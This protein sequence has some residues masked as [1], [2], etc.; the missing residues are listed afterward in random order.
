MIK[1]PKEI[2]SYKN[3]HYVNDKLKESNKYAPEVN[4][5]NY[6][7]DIM[8]VK[9]TPKQQE[10][11]EP[12]R[13]LLSKGHGFVCSTGKK[14]QTTYE[15][16]YLSVD[17]QI[18]MQGNVC[19]ARDN[20]A[21]GSINYDAIALYTK[22]YQDPKTHKTKFVFE[23]YNWQTL[24]SFSIIFDVEKDTIESTFPDAVNPFKPTEE[25]CGMFLLQHGIELNLYNYQEVKITELQKSYEEQFASV[26][27]LGSSVGNSFKSL[28][29]LGLMLPRLHSYKEF[30]Q[31]E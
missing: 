4:N 22:I 18:D 21:T 25:E 31:N 27:N 26:F 9:L 2:R 17:I 29:S 11:I 16:G 28:A 10:F 7:L 6:L 24:I 8:I 3:F 12:I 14:A 20:T 1:L 30:S 13:H 15:N 5:K 19:S 23:D